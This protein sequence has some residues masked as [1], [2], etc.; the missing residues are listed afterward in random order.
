MS[1]DTTKA[2]APVA[3]PEEVTFTLDGIEMSAPKGTLIIRAAESVGID[4]PRFCDHPLLDPAGACRQCMVDIPDGGNG[5]PMKPSAA[6]TAS[7]V[8]PSTS[9]PTTRAEPSGRKPNPHGV[10]RPAA[11]VSDTATVPPA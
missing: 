1:V 6:C 5:R 7:S 11:M 2:H 3:K 4:I 8:A 9:R 10:C